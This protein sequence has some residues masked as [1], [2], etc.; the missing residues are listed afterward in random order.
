MTNNYCSL[1]NTLF[2]FVQCVSLLMKKIPA[3]LVFLM[4]LAGSFQFLST[5]KNTTS[6]ASPHI[7]NVEKVFTIPKTY[8]RTL[9]KDLKISKSFTI[10]L[11]V[12]H[13]KN[14]ELP[15]E[16]AKL[17]SNHGAVTDTTK[18]WEINHAIATR[19]A[20]MLEKEGITVE[21]LPATIPKGYKADMFVAVHAD[22]NPN[23]KLTG[24]KA[25]GAWN[26]ETGN[27]MS[28]AETM[29]EE[30]IRT[31]RMKKDFQVTRAMKEYY[32]FNHKKF[33]H[34]IH[35]DTP[36]IIVET[37]FVTN[38]YDKKI[39]LE[40]PEI[41]ARGLANGIIASIHMMEKSRHD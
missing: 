32:A 36:G 5:P 39:L 15:E 28:I 38:E 30:Y 11:Q 22:Q 40:Y 34:A 37:G 20:A 41:P 6:P 18:E 27:A 16:L 10:G 2:L 9:D 24:F 19:T 1:C 13:W 25:T 29:E 26:D 33:T 35:P 7:G 4:V 8:A 23:K 21:L 3:V 17:R 31:T 14:T 12:G